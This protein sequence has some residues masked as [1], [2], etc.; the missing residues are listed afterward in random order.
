[1]SEICTIIVGEE[2]VNFHAHRAVLEQSPVF[3]TLLK[4]KQEA[5]QALRVNFPHQSPRLVCS[6]LQYL[7]GHELIQPI[8]GASQKVELLCE[9]YITAGNL[10]LDVLQSVIIKALDVD[11]EGDMSDAFPYAAQKVYEKCAASGPFRKLFKEKIKENIRKESLNTSEY[12]FYE[13][14]T[15]VATGGQLAIDVAQ[16]LMELYADKVVICLNEGPNRRAEF[17]ERQVAMMH[18][19]NNVLRA[20][21]DAANLRFRDIENAFASAHTQAES[22]LEA[23]GNMVRAAQ[24]QRESVET[25]LENQQARAESAEARLRELSDRALHWQHCSI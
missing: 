1:M 11:K 13:V 14:G 23:A 12:H 24:H 6:I 7:Y 2:E 21:M 15:L 9:T 17:A 18:E 5:N 16:A 10:E 22:D 20:R 25:A 19:S 8:F 3:A 4:H